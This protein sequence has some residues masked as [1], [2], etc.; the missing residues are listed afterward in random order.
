MAYLTGIN[1]VFYRAIC[2]V[3]AAAAI[4]YFGYVFLSLGGGEALDIMGDT[5]GAFVPDE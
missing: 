4:A 2:L 3:L 1:R 5:P